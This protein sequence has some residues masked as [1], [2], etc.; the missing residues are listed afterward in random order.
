M[1]GG[2]PPVVTLKSK[3]A[4]RVNFPLQTARE[5]DDLQKGFNKRDLAFCNDVEIIA[6]Y[7]VQF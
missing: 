3:N 4:L 5:S 7:S 2:G 1:G 6:E